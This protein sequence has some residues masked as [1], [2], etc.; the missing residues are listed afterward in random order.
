MRTINI[1]E[2]KTHL[3]RFVGM[4][5]QGQNIVI[6]RAG[7]PVAR[8]VPYESSDPMPKK[9]LGFLLGQF[10][11]TAMVKEAGKEEIQAMFEGRE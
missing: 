6:A 3:S 9:R 1:H 8:L 7:E 10:G 5:A 4:A 11:V 2:A